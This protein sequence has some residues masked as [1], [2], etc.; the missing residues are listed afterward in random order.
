MPAAAYI[1][2]A[3][4]PL[5]RDRAEAVV[6]QWLEECGLDVEYGESDRWIA[7]VDEA[8]PFLPEA[9]ALTVEVQFYPLADAGSQV[10]WQFRSVEPDGPLVKALA[11]GLHERLQDEAGWVVDLWRVG[12]V[13]GEAAA[14][15]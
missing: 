5:E 15:R 10:R 8:L 14:N 9:A 3:H 6:L 2:S 4:T 11:E 13:E 12:G 7:W 1:L